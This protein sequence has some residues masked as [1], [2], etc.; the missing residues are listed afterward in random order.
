MLFSFESFATLNR[1]L[2]GFWRLI[3]LNL[4]WTATTVLGLG[5]LG[6]GPASYALA[7]YLD[8]WFRHGET[9]PLL[10]THLRHVREQWG[11]SMLMGLVLSGA[12]AVILVNLLS[13]TD[14]YLRAANL[15]AA[16]LLVL[17][18]AYVFFVLAAMDVPGLRRPLITALL[19]GLGSLHWTILGATA[20]AIAEAV[21]LRYA[22]ALFPLLGAVL[23]FAVV[24]VILRPV[25]RD[26]GAA[27]DTALDADPSAPTQ[28]PARRTDAPA[29]RPAPGRALPLTKGTPA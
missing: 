16:V 2:T 9:P 8:R 10:R 1:W 11:R 24:A 6:I 15:L 4:L 7:R 23:P 20:V 18:G 3:A 17:I 12:G 14:W 19:L 27:A 5:V 29:P 26:L 28:T 13:L 21:M 22:L 25:L